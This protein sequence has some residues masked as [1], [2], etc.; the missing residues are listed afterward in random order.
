ML[1]YSRIL[2]CSIDNTVHLWY[3]TETSTVLLGK[4]AMVNSNSPADFWQPEWLVQTSDSS[5]RENEREWEEGTACR[6]F[7]STPV[8]SD[9]ATRYRSQK[10]PTASKAQQVSRSVPLVQSTCVRFFGGAPPQN[11]AAA[12]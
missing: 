9:P 12:R 6:V 1:K 4:L 8:C 11:T 2:T 7:T 5:E 10:G 3:I